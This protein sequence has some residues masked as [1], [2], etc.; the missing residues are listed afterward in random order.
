MPFIH[1]T[2]F[3]YGY[4]I[5]F[6]TGV[7]TLQTQTVLSHAN[8]FQKVDQHFENPQTSDVIRTTPPVSAMVPGTSECG[9]RSIFFIERH[10]HL[11]RYTGSPAWHAIMDRL[12]Q[13][14]RVRRAGTIFLRF[15]KRL[16][17]ERIHWTR[18][19]R[20]KNILQRESSFASELDPLEAIWVG[21]G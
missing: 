21:E 19:R 3:F 14:F 20:R 7:W 1:V 17:S 10:L 16:R 2:M 6:S 12:T 15:C 18:R 9:G 11:S 4:F 5:S 13:S 8:I